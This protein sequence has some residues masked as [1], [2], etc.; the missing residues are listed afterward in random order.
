[1][2]MTIERAEKLLKEIREEQAAKVDGLPPL[3]RDRTPLRGIVAALDMALDALK[4]KAERENPAPLT[5][6]ELR[7]MK[8]G[9]VIWHESIQGLDGGWLVLRN[10][11]IKM[12]QAEITGIRYGKTWIAYRHKPKG[13]Q[14]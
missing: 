6:E 4:E 12:F 1:M 8:A 11:D 5:L 2:S 13:V 7:R 3:L 10:H 14:E 9:E